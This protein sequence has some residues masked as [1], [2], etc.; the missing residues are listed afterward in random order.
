MIG[1]ASLLVLLST[2]AFVGGPG[3][4]APQ[5]TQAEEPMQCEE[6]R[7]SFDSYRHW[8]TGT[9][10]AYNSPFG[11]D[12]CTNCTSAK[13]CHTG[14]V[15]GHCSAHHDNCPVGDA[16]APAKLKEAIE[17]SDPRAVSIILASNSK[18][19]KVSKDGYALVLDCQGAIAA[20]YRLSPA[21]ASA[22]SRGSA[23]VA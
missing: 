3:G 7:F 21:L 13:P 1:S 19:F 9:V 5:Q 4:K 6:C 18:S 2:F 10:C 14:T 15:L 12:G 23:K 16:S 8:N 22:I 17:K 11:Q 20:A